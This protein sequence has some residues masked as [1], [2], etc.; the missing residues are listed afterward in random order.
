MIQ[1]HMKN[2]ANYSLKF[3]IN[4]TIRHNAQRSFLNK[5]FLNHADVQFSAPNKEI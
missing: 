4:F 2:K 3:D 1:V 5:R